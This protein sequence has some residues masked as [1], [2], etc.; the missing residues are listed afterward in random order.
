MVA[1]VWTH[2]IGVTGKLF[3]PTAC[4][5]A[6]QLAFANSRETFHPPEK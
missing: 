3:S 6:T 1:L 2:A 4:G 5:T